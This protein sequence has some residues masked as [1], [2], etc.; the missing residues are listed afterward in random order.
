MVILLSPA[1]TL[2]MSP[3]GKCLASE[4]RMLNQAAELLVECQKLGKPGIK[5]MQGTSDAVTALNFQR[6]SSFNTQE[7]KQAALAFDGPAYRGLDAA[8]FSEED[9]VFAQTHLRILW[10]KTRRSCSARAR[11]RCPHAECPHPQ[12]SN[13][14]AHAPRS[15]LYGVLRP[16]DL[17]RP[18]RLEMSNALPNSRGRNLYECAAPPQP[19][20]CAPP[21]SA[22]RPRAGRF[23][24]DEISSALEADMHE[25]LRGQS[26]APRLVAP[27]TPAGG[28]SRGPAPARRPRGA[29]RLTRA[30]AGAGLVRSSTAPARSTS[31]PCSSARCGGR[32]RCRRPAS[33]A[34]QLPS[35]ASAVCDAR[36]SAERGRPDV[37]N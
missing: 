36:H 26:E 25:Q 31:G 2:D 34:A 37:S 23:W 1:K 14:F 33:S 22:H 8:S 13:A 4:P 7:Q 32:P 28:P 19:T 10:C 29:G 20:P 24:G 11:P 12:D 9:R 27:A 6:F 18:Y 17:I 35:L 15:G 16:F 30:R 21:R 3:A 5:K